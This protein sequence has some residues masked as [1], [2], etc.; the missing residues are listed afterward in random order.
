MGI[1]WNISFSKLAAGGND[2]IC[3]DNTAG[4]LDVPLHPDNLPA[5]VR[6][7][8]RRGLAIG[9]DGVIVGC[10]LGNGGGIDIVARFLEPDGSEAELC[11]NGT[12]CF[13]LWAIENEIVSGPEVK[14]LTAAGTAVGRVVDVEDGRVRVC[15]P[16]PRDLQFG[17]DLEVKG[18]VWQLD[19]IQTGVPHAIAFVDRLDRLDVDHWGT[20]IR[21]HDHFQ[22]R[23]VNAN[24]VQV[25]EPGHIGVRTFEFGVEDET[26]ACGT[27]SAAAAIVSALR[28]RWPDSYRTGDTPVRVDVR[29]GETLLV[30]FVCSEGDQITDVCLETRARPIYS[31]VCAAEFAA[32]LQAA[33]QEG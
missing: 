19:Y 6:A 30:W 27:G 26:L 8:C 5:F 33:V 25:F 20:G 22:P 4:K 32:E 28:F 12:A 1:P 2:F 24:F 15:V 13:T 21:H 3:L 7:L 9:A 16:N 29:G 23:G 11:G 17:I 18:E 10:D 14:I 31:G